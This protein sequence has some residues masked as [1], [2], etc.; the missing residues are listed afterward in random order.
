[1]QLH[2][3]LIWTFNG[4][5]DN[6]S[7]FWSWEFSSK[8]QSKEIS[9]LI[10]K[11]EITKKKWNWGDF[12]GRCETCGVGIVTLISSQTSSN[13]HPP[14]TWVRGA[15]H[16]SHLKST[17]RSKLPWRIATPSVDFIS[18]DVDV[19]IK[20]QNLHKFFRAWWYI[21]Y[22]TLAQRGAILN[23]IIWERSDH[24]IWEL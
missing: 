4:T 8:R 5:H 10:K 7:H 16:P 9:T 23:N 24:S 12:V 15:T 21:V 13:L 17:F 18:M 2:V 6:L 11:I 3:N 14:P 20:T 22:Q 19:L 1:M